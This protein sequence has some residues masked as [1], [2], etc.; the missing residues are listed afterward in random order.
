V[1]N[2]TDPLFR[3]EANIFEQPFFFL[4]DSSMNA[5]CL[6]SIVT[7]HSII[8]DIYLNTM[9]QHLDK[10]YQFQAPIT[11]PKITSISFN[12]KS[13]D[14]GEIAYKDS[15]VATAGFK[16]RGIKPLF[17]TAVTTDCGCTVASY[18][19]DIILPGDSSSISI[20]YDSRREGYFDRKVFVYSNAKE[21]PVVLQITGRV[22][23][24]Q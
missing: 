20:E 14:L 22:R 8:T 3:E 12:Q 1:Y 15:A 16:N 23:E 10:A 5:K 6:F 4:L 7:N 18:P 13:F 2:S 17:L 11:T 19:K 21:S 9:K 24:H